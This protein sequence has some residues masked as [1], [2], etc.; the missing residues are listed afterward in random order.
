MYHVPALLEMDVRYEL[1]YITII[2]HMFHVIGI[3]HLLIGMSLRYLKELSI[4]AI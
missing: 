2:F 1:D 3:L 4:L